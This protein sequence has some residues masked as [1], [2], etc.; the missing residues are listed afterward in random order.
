VS[1]GAKVGRILSSTNLDAYGYPRV[2]LIQDGK[3]SVRKIHRMVAQAWIPNPDNLPVVNHK[4]AIRRGGTNAASNLEWITQKGNAEHA[5]ANGLYACVKG[6]E[7]SN[8]KLTWEQVE[9]I[10]TRYAQGNLTQTCLAK[11][12]GITQANISAIVLNK[13]WVSAA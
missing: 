4:K 10:R 12:Y 8:S 7:N 3:Q 13:I 11:M 5:S 9:Q 2:S 1:V 6:A